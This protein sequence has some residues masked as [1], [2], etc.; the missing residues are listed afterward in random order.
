MRRNQQH[1]HG[2]CRGSPIAAKTRGG[3][4]GTCAH[5]TAERAAVNN[6]VPEIA[7]SFSLTV[8]PKFI[9]H[10]KGKNRVCAA[11]DGD[12]M[13]ETDVYEEV[14]TGGD[15]G[16]SAHAAASSSLAAAGEVLGPLTTHGYRP[17]STFTMPY[18][19]CAVCIRATRV[20]RCETIFYTTNGG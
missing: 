10:A 20:A 5:G 14:Q 16:A 18:A 19:E 12:G 8:S 3:Q 2:A 7:I 1:T 6:S 15:G 4:A 11:G 17:V 9:L 13:M